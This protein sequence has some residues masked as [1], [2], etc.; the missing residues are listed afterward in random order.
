MSRTH[1]LRAGLVALASAG[2]ALLPPAASGSPAAPVIT[3]DKFFGKVAGW[4]IGYSASL[5]G[6]LAA[7]SYQDGTTIWFGFGG[8]TDQAFLAFTNPRWKSIE[9]GQS[10][11]VRLLAHGRGNWRG[12]FA[13]FERDGEMGIFTAGL[14]DRFVSDLAAS[15]GLEVAADGRRIAV[16]SLVGSTDALASVGDCQ[17][18]SA[19]VQADGAPAQAAP[20]AGPR[21]EARAQQEAEARLKADRLTRARGTGAA[22]ID[23]AAGFVKANGDDQQVLQYIQH[24]ADLKTALQGADPGAI[25]SGVAM[26][27]AELKADPVYTAYES[28]QGV[29]RQRE[30][31][32]YL[33]DALRT[34]KVQNSVLVHALVQDPTSAF[35][36]EFLSLQK[37]ASAVLAAPDLDRAKTVMGLIDA[38]IDRGGLVASYELAKANAERDVLP[39][40]ARQ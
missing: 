5:N 4:S 24:I 17:K 16:L 14:K 35:A 34:L 9:A 39:T 25:E 28:R 33:S 22:A 36:P 37:Q 15:G 2:C 10:Y 3:V 26:L 27:S 7:A 13:G 19:T 6:C 32:R 1:R 30:N 29:E 21:S 11:E 18:S 23:D 31:A 20:A 40:Q 8:S 12:S 38:A